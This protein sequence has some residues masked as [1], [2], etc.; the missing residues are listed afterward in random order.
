MIVL[1][2]YIEIQ[3]LICNVHSLTPDATYIGTKIQPSAMRQ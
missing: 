2:D 1:I 3:E